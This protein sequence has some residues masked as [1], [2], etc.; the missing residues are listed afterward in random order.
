MRLSRDYSQMNDPDRNRAFARG[1]FWRTDEHS[2]AHLSPIEAQRERDH[3]ARQKLGLA[4]PR[5][6]A[7]LFAESFA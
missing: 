2:P 7:A 5:A 4:I 1:R 6:S 3:A